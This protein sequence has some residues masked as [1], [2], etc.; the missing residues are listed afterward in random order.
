MNSFWEGTSE[1]RKMAV[2]GLCSLISRNFLNLNKLVVN[3][4]LVS[5]FNQQIR[6]KRTCTLNKRIF[7][8]RKSQKFWEEKELTP[9]SKAYI[10][11][12][13]IDDYAVS[14]A[15]SPL[16]EGTIQPKNWTPETR[17]TGLLGV[18]IGVIPQWKKDGTKILVTLLQV[19]D[20]HVIRYIP[21][22]EFSKMPSFKTKWQK[23]D[24]KRAA[25]VVGALSCDPSSFSEYYVK[26]FAEAGIPPKRKVTRFV[27]TEDAKL[28]PG[29]QLHINHFRAGDYVDC[30][31]KTIGHGFQGVMKRWGF[32]GGPATH[33]ATKWHRRPGSIGSGRKKKVF[34]G[35]KMPGRMGYKWR[36]AGAL[37]IWK[38][39]YKY[40]VL[41]VQGCSIPGPTHCYV[42]IM[43]TTNEKRRTIMMKNPPPLPT[44]IPEQHNK[45]DEEESYDPALFQFSQP[46]VMFEEKEVVKTKARPG[47]SGAKKKA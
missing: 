44:Y 17:R 29:T 20:N 12:K 11:S 21:P 31:A 42:L 28:P 47:Q 8:E 26:Q 32:S 41:Y 33:G 35:K 27:I 40:N 6:E 18:K 3:K 10:R 25:L 19:I 34:R 16:R 46:T 13:A 23:H 39:D 15:N 5:N 36:I 37:K 43:D 2:V 14:Q 45:T 38:I 24:S 30:E 4:C 7:I 22:E 1:S 9:E